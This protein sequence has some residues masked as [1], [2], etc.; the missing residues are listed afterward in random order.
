MALDEALMFLSVL[1]VLRIYPSKSQG[2]IIGRFQTFNDEIDFQACLKDGIEVVRRI[3]GGGSIFKIPDGEINYSLIF[4]VDDFPCFFDVKKSYTVVLSKMKE[5]I[6][7]IYDDVEITIYPGSSDLVINNRKIS[8]NAQARK[9]RK[10]LI[11]GTILVSVNKNKMFKYIRMPREKYTVRGFS[12]PE[13]FITDLAS[14][15][16]RRYC[17]DDICSHLIESFDGWLNLSTFQDTITNR[18]EELV[19]ELVESK[20]SSLEWLLNGR[21]IGGTPKLI[22]GGIS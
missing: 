8:G 17:V 6:E 15:S 13:D 2:I 21:W 12:R 22:K 3:T 5:A 7:K 10:V 11:H 4:P 20:Y 9:Y 16:K 1:P 18:E 19:R 14:H